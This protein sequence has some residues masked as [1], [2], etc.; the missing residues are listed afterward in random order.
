MTA[1]IV[2]VITPV[3]RPV[4]SEL[5]KC[6]SSARHENVEHI[7][8]IDGVENAT[9]Q[10]KVMHLAEQYGATV[11]VRT[12]NGGISQATNDGVAASHGEF[13]LFLDQDDYLEKHWFR[14]F[15]I[16]AETADF[17]Y[18][19]AY[20]V[21]KR[22]RILAR[23]LKPDWSPTRLANNM[24]ACHFFAV[25]REL[26]DKVGGMRQEFDGAQDHDIALRISRETSRCVHIPHPL[27]N[28]RQSAAS[29]A[30][31]PDNKP[32]AFD[33]GV[34]AAQEHIDHL[35]LS[36]KVEPIHGSPGCYVSVFSPRVDPISVAVPTAFGKGE[37][38]SRTF[39]EMLLLSLR[40]H[41]GT[42]PGDE[43][44]LVSAGEDTTGILDGLQK[45]V[46]FP[47][48]HIVDRSPFNFSARCNIAIDACSNELNLLL[49]DDIE[50]TAATSLDQ[51]VGNLKQQGVGLV[52]A[53]LTYP[54]GSVQH[55]GH[56]YNFAP[57]HA[58]YQLPNRRAALGELVID[59]EIDGV[60]GALFLQQKS[61]WR[62][63]GGFNENF[64]L[65]YNDVD[66]CLKVRALGYRII[67]VNSTEAFHH[68]SQTRE[69]AVLQEEMDRLFARWPYSFTADTYTRN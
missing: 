26:F 55:A 33:A 58:Y 60:T 5:R 51:L 10:H 24:Y 67:Q 12:A 32:W 56:R 13:V 59:R 9:K 20:V 42:V 17:V 34:A 27:Y 66:Y 25:R 63:V 40:G 61:V 39:I 18:S 6:L 53:L 68:E 19:D 36:A 41:L 65:N 22:G 43:V 44:V 31:N 21:S 62:E 35:G 48:T 46:D 50:F 45:K 4:L 30:A 8:V 49:N 57:T 23:L 2:S 64:P 28:W 14:M 52:G 47:I 15:E 29:T 54:D 69:T 16:A 1:P 11:I 3:Y 7:L 37:G 38:T